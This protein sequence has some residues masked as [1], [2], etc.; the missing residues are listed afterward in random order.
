M[1]QMVKPELDATEGVM[2]ECRDGERLVKV[3]ERLLGS[4]SSW[5]GPRTI[6]GEALSRLHVSI[7][8]LPGMSRR[9]QHRGGRRFLSWSRYGLAVWLKAT[10]F[11]SSFLPF[12]G[13]Q[14]DLH[15]GEQSTSEL[16]VS[17]SVI[18]TYQASSN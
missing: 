3:E 6:T 17:A 18:P 13:T 8:S 11:A 4:F 7:P 15:I 9:A 14:Q 2:S 5:P 1:I 16:T 10:R 12:S